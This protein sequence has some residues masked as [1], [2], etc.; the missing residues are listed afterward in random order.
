MTV[1]RTKKQKKKNKNQSAIT[2]QEEIP[3]TSEQG[4]SDPT[5]EELFLELGLGDLDLDGA[6][7]LLLVAALVVG[8]VFNGGGKQSVDEGSLS[9]S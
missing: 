7:N 6:V 2:T 4:E 8:V 9:Q 1:R 3:G 5:F